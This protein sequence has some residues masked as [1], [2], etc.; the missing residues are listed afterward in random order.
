MA[1]DLE[2]E[3]FSDKIWSNNLDMLSDKESATTGSRFSGVTGVTLV[4]VVEWDGDDD[5]EN[6][7]NCTQKI[8]LLFP[9]FIVTFSCPKP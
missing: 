1:F 9:D 2:R 5:P 4:D 6:P 7:M 8:P 3:L